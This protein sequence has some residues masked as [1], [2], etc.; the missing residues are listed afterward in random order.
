MPVGLTI[1][2]I[3]GKAGQVYYPLTHVD[4]PAREPGPAEVVVRI[5]AAALN[6]RDFF[7]R[8]RLYGGISFGV[9]LMSDACGTVIRTG[10]SPSARSWLNRRVIINPGTGWDSDPDGPEDP[11]GYRILGGTKGLPLGTAVDELVIGAAELEPAPDHLNDHEAA[12]LPLAGLTAWRATV[13]KS[14]NAR[15]G[16]NILITGIGGG[17]ALFAL[18]FAVAAGANAYVTSG[19]Q[20]KIDRAIAMGAKG[21]VSYKEKGWEKKLKDM[22]PKDRRFLDAIV[23]GAGADVCDKGARLLRDGGIIS[24]Y[25]MTVSP[26]MTWGMPDVLKNIELRGSTM[27]SRKEFADMVAFVADRKIRPVVSKVAKGLD[28]LSEL[29]ALFEEMKNGSQFGKL[30]VQIASSSGSK[31]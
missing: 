21:G 10:S 24:Q 26:K 22:L 9:P 6:H 31:L 8:Q 19:S 28:N 20:D 3:P 27:G 13:T 15:P 12:A 14:A 18:A 23:D 7:I 5:H 25:G 17:V 30:V 2:E 11:R 1:K 4:I 16:R 29:D